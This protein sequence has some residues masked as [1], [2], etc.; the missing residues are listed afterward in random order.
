LAVSTLP[1]A[2]T[3]QYWIAVVDETFS[4]TATPG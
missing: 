2:S 1:A 4:G 3:D